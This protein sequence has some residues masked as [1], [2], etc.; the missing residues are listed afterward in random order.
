LLSS[1]LYQVLLEGALLLLGGDPVAYLPSPTVQQQL[2]DS[3][4]DAMQVAIF[5]T[6]ELAIG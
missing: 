6:V 1:G 2:G 3:L 4:G 5:L